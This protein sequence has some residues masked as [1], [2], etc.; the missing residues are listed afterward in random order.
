VSIGNTPGS[1]VAARWHCRAPQQL[2]LDKATGSA[3][4]GTIQSKKRRTLDDLVIQK[5]DLTT[6]T[7]E[8]SLGGKGYSTFFAEGGQENGHLTTRFNG[9]SVTC[10]AILHQ[11]LI[12]IEHGVEKVV[13]AHGALEADG[14][15]AVEQRLAARQLAGQRTQRSHGQL[16]EYT[17]MQLPLV[18]SELL[19]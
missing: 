2:T 12:A 10:C 16:I 8:T 9:I 7:E 1:V 19:L 6:Q 4:K 14:D 5:G 18:G 3:R 17:A 15:K 11:L 13:I